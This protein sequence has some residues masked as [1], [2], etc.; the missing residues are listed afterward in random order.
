MFFIETKSGLK[1]ECEIIPLTIGLIPK[2]NDGWSFNWE[3]AFDMNPKTLF[4]LIEKQ[5]QKL[6]GAVQLLN[7]GGMLIMEL[8]ELAPFNIGSK[9]RY[10]KVAGCLIAFCCRE[11]IKLD[12]DYKGYITFVS[13]TELIE[14]YK[15][16]YHATQAIGNRM[17]IDPLAGET[18]I[19]QYLSHEQEN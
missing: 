9:G 11:S 7:D 19:K 1:V 8:I 10:P 12:S 18:L 6:H 17:Y 2:K 3:N 4:G 16:K 14:L 15:N 5:S 13:K